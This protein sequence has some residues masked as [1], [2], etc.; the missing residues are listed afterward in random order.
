MDEKTIEFVDI[1]KSEET[2]EIVSGKV[3]E[4]KLFDVQV[5]KDRLSDLTQTSEQ[6]GYEKARVDA[7]IESIQAL[8]EQA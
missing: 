3:K 2:G 6:L 1:V 7:E 8:L 4:S 5:Y